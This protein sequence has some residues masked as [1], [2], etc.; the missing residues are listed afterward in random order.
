MFRVCRSVR[1]SLLAS[2]ALNVLIA[3]GPAHAATVTV[4]APTAKG[5]S[6]SEVKLPITVKGAPGVG[7]IQFGL[8]YD[9]AVLE[10]VVGPDGG[11]VVDAGDLAGD[12]G[13]IDSDLTPGRLAI[14]FATIQGVKGDGTMF[15]AH[16]K[17]IGKA[18]QISPLTLDRTRAWEATN[19]SFEILA[20]NEAGTF[21]VAKASSS[22]PWWIIG[23][24]GGLLLLLL[25]V[26][27]R[28]RKD[29]PEGAVAS[30]AVPMAPSASPVAPPSPPAP[31]APPAPAP[32]AAPAPPPPP[33]PPP[34][35]TPTHS[36]PPAGIDA[37]A[38]ADASAGPTAHLE[39][40]TALQVV[41]RWGEW[42]RVVGANGWTGW[43]DHRWLIAQP[44]APS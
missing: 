5:S 4:A 16:F 32:P 30:T 20:T 41:E 9:P 34:A 37:Y 25:L 2:I 33:P 36:S 31:P 26:L 23:V 8:Q 39:A 28:R 40:G 22:F 3:T 44:G 15:L 17:V 13:L 35:W 42:A 19:D 14:K 21:T 29:E 7:A 12:G 43:V 1:L 24:A 38:G 27:A 18:G 11:G 6:G 10:A